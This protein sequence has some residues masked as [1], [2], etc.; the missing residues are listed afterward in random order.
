MTTFLDMFFPVFGERFLFVARLKLLT[1]HYTHYTQHLEVRDSVSV[2]YG[3]LRA[4]GARRGRR[5]HR[6]QALQCAEPEQYPHPDKGSQD[7]RRIHSCDRH[8]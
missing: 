8:V 7:S 3:I 1:R 5:G 6:L 4:M 2:Q